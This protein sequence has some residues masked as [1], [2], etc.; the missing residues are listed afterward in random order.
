MNHY[1]HM[2]PKILEEELQATWAG[3]QFS[4]RTVFARDE[5]SGNWMMYA[6]ALRPLAAD[7]SAPALETFEFER[8]VLK[9]DSV[10]LPELGT[11]LNRA[12]IAMSDLARKPLSTTFYAQTHCERVT[13]ENYWMKSP[14]AVWKW[15]SQPQVNTPPGELLSPDGPY[16][17]DVDEAAKDWLQLGG[18]AG[19]GDGFKGQLLLLLPETRAFI[20]NHSWSEDDEHLRLNVAGSAMANRAV[21][22]KGA[23]WCDKVPTQ[24]QQVVQDGTATLFVSRDAHRLELNLLSQDGTV[25]EQHRENLDSRWRMRFLG[26]RHRMSEG[27][28]KKA[29]KA[30]EGSQIEFK[31]FIALP[32][33]KNPLS[34]ENKGK[35]DEVLE[36]VVA[37]ANAEGG[38]I[39]IGVTNDVR[40][41]GFKEDYARYYGT[42][43]TKE[44][45]DTYVRELGVFV[46]DE[47]YLPAEVNVSSLEHENELLVLVE[48]PSAK[49]K[50]V[51]L[52][53]DAR[54]LRRHG[55]S[56]RSVPPDEWSPREH[57]AFSA[58]GLGVQ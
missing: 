51:S 10:S 20:Q 56:N 28:V 22:V 27:R 55:A 15:G 53:K 4:R 7:A 21:Q 33:H 3:H 16:Y 43:V 9:S 58:L 12:S 49:P 26:S 37:F 17:P 34:S 31:P 23:Y 47:M 13:H 45:L 52:K 35:M 54:L 46:R 29:L 38:T 24:I 39:F 48:V 32:K 2:F 40:V 5:S 57:S 11:F 30:G 50:Y 14:G 25:F 1:N 41:M 6:C 19:R 42:R 8:A 36:T 44:L 18:H